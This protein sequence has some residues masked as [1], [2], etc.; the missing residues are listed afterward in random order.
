MALIPFSFQKQLEH[1]AVEESHSSPLQLV[2][3]IVRNVIFFGEAMERGAEY[4]DRAGSCEK[5]WSAK[6]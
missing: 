3:F 1:D 4:D 2:D 5:A 6:Q